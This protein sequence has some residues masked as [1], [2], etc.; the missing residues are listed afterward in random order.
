MFELLENI[1]VQFWLIMKE[2]YKIYKMSFLCQDA[3]QVMLENIC[4]WYF[5]Y[6]SFFLSWK[7]NFNI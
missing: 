2:K 7:G 3:K 5:V 6:T 1:C 4:T